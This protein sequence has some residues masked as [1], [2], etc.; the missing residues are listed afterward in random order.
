MSVTEKRMPEYQIN[1]PFARTPL[2]VSDSQTENPVLWYTTAQMELLNRTG[3][4]PIKLERYTYGDQTATY[5]W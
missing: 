4:R 1:I 5:D 2:L 3:V